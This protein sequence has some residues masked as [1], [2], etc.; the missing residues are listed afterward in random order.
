MLIAV[1]YKSERTGVYQPTY[2]PK[3]LVDSTLW[4]PHLAPPPFPAHNY[5]ILN[6]VQRALL[7]LVSMT[8]TTPCQQKTRLHLHPLSAMSGPLVRP[9]HPL[10]KLT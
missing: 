7:E 1:G 9:V 6:H 4:A 3:S 5:N 2:T 10:Y 8:A